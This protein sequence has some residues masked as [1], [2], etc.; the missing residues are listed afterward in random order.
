MDHIER[1][2]WN[3]KIRSINELFKLIIHARTISLSL[4]TNELRLE[5]LRKLY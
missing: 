4:E 1:I 3:I 2:L 5:K